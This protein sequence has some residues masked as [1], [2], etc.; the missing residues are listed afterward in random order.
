M[1]PVF[2]A[3]TKI[4]NIASWTFGKHLYPY[5]P[6]IGNYYR[7]IGTNSLEDMLK[8]DASNYIEAN[9]K[10]VYPSKDY[11]ATMKAVRDIISIKSTELWVK[12]DETK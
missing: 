2:E 8:A 1:K 12:V 4:G 9:F 10:K 3:A 7:V 6:E 5:S 11:A